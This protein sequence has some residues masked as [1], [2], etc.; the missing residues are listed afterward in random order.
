MVVLMLM[1]VVVVQIHNYQVV[2]LETLVIDILVEE[3]EVVQHI[4]TLHQMD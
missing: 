2:V 4:Y 3:V 1:V